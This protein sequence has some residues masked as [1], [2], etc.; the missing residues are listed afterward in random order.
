[1]YI[2]IHTHTYAYVYS[3]SAHVHNTH[4]RMYSK[5]HYITSHQTT[6]HYISIP[7]Q[8]IRCMYICLFVQLCVRMHNWYICIYYLYI[9][10]HASMYT[11][12]A[13]P[14]FIHVCVRTHTSY[15]MNAYMYMHGVCRCLLR[16]SP[17]G[18]GGL[19]WK[20]SAALPHDLRLTGHK[21][22]QQKRKQVP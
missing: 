6:L 15:T 20:T 10:I 11:D 14:T 13:I 12:I 1:M 5:L 3:L 18:H 8:Y 17:R 19:V 21:C 16:D 22:R 9:P 7:L 4:A 2:Y